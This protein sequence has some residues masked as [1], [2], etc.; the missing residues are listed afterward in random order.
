MKILTIDENGWP[1]RG[2][3]EVMNHRL[4]TRLVEAGHECRMVCGTKGE[5][6][7]DGIEFIRLEKSDFQKWDNPDD[8]PARAAEVPRLM[9]MQGWIRDFKPDV[10]FVGGFWLGSAI[11]AAKRERVPVALLRH[12]KIGHLKA[13]AP[14]DLMIYDSYYVQNESTHKGRHSVVH[15]PSQWPVKEP[16]AS[17]WAGKGCLTQLNLNFMKGVHLFHALAKAL[18]DRRFIGV[19][20]GWGK[21]ERYPKPNIRYATKNRFP[22]EKVLEE[23]TSVLLMPSKYESF[24]LVALEAQCFGIPV[25]ATDIPGIREALGSGA[26]FC[27][28]LNVKQWVEAVRRLEDPAEYRR[29]SEL[30]IANAKA[31]EAEDPR[32]KFLRLM[33]ELAARGKQASAPVPK[34]ARHLTRR[35]RRAQARA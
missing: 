4:L 22:L 7:V 6:V 15:P 30:A 20:G 16:R 25:V 27:D 19:E 11:K 10:V 28:H 14:A 34:P 31:K 13:A 9:E 8:L 2:G 21:Q 26:I 5:S 18:P 23:W 35:E 1:F 29:F 33:E 17:E 32:G 3:H 12:M 24:G